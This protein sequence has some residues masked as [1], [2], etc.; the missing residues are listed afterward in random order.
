M[1]QWGNVD[2]T[3]PAGD[4]CLLAD[5]LEASARWP[6]RGL[7]VLGALSIVSGLCGRHTYGPT[8]AAPNLYITAVAP[9]GEG[10]DSV[11]KS[12]GKTLRL[13][14]QEELYELSFPHSNTALEDLMVD[15]PG[16]VVC[17]DEIGTSLFQ[18]ILSKKAGGWERDMKATINS[19]HSRRYGEEPF[20][21]KRHA[22]DR[23]SGGNKPAGV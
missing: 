16:V 9:T 4:L 2:W 1:A 3:R 14:R 19:L 7:A 17:V 5:H 11:F 21:T 22:K 20:T 23:R 18:K 15:K 6:N 8:G 12:I 13:V 10:K